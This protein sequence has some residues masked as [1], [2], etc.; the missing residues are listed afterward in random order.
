[1]HQRAE[2]VA[3]L[4]LLCTAAMILPVTGDATSEP[5]ETTA[6]DDFAHPAG[7][8]LTGSD[9]E[10][11]GSDNTVLRAPPVPDVHKTDRTLL[12]KV[13]PQS[14]PLPPPP[15]TTQLPPPACGSVCECS[16]AAGGGLKMECKNP[17]VLTT[18]PDLGPENTSVTEL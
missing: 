16:R 14:P 2:T 1:M 13:L 10:Y 18:L 6:V 4:I 9:V 5:K 3:S 17:G 12:A 8:P 15:V 7:E 11:G